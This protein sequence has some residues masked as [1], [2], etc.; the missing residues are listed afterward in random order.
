M[1]IISIEFKIKTN[2][3]NSRCNKKKIVTDGDLS[4]RSLLARPAD[5]TLPLHE[6]LRVSFSLIAF[7]TMD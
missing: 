1:W 6:S 7:N 4:E 5:A 3:E 2:N